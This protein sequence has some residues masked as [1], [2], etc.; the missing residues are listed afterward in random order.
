MQL[1]FL[2]PSCLC[3]TSI[4]GGA[5]IGAEVA[6]LL[7]V[8]GAWCGEYVAKCAE[9]ICGYVGECPIAYVALAILTPKS[10]FS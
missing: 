2:G 3:T 4:S 7:E 10:S 9:D 6:I 1:D 5:V 8:R